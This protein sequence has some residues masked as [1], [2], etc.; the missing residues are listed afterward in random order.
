MRLGAA[1]VKMNGN[2]FI[3]PRARVKESTNRYYAKNI[4]MKENYNPTAKY[5]DRRSRLINN[6]ALITITFAATGNYWADLIFY[7]A[8]RRRAHLGNL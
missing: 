3:I 6:R 4:L 7:A 2:V 8:P 1:R 5:I